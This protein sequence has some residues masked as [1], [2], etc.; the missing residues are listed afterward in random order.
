MGEEDDGML[1]LKED[2][3]FIADSHYPHHGEEFPFLLQKLLSGN[4]RA[5]QLFLMGDNF[6]LLFGYNDY[7]QT[8]SKKAISLLQ[9]LSQTMEIYYFE[10]NHDFCLQEIFPNIHVYNREA[11][12]VMFA[13]GSKK[14]AISHGDKYAAGLVYDIYCKLLR[15]AVTLKV[16]RPFQK[17]IINHRIKKLSQK[18]ICYSFEG[19]KDRV[20]AIMRHYDNVD[21]VIEGHFHQAK[22]IGDYVSL[23]SL[24]CQKQVAVIKGGNI[25]F[26]D[27]DGLS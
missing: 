5:S 19:L 21:L 8:F 22:V 2:A 7:I 26:V 4:I 15:N 11:Q 16:L 9:V 1:M 14:V 13:M 24:A 3:L 25:L 6:D 27:I 20:E 18:Y 17:Q 10:G 12:P 23:P